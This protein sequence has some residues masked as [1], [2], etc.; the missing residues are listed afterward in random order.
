MNTKLS[1]NE[2]SGHHH[3]HWPR[4]S[5]VRMVSNKLVHNPLF[6]MMVALI[7]FV[8]LMMVLSLFAK[9]TNTPQWPGTG[10]PYGI[11]LWHVYP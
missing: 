11:G 7:A 1:M 4:M 8:V 2:W 10:Y 3:L 6:W 5:D 9:G